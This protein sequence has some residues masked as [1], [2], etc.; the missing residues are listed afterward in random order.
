[1]DPDLKRPTS[2]ELSFNIEREITSGLSG[3]ASYVYKNMR[4]VWGEYDA[5]RG[6]Q[7]TVPITIVDPGPDNRLSTPGDNQ[8]FETFDRPAGIDQD[9]VYTNIPDAD[10]SFQTIEFAVNRRFADRWMLLTSFGYTWSSMLHDVTGYGRLTNNQTYLPVK[11]LFGDNGIETSTTWNYKV[12]GRYV[13]PWDIGL[14]GSWKAQS[15]QNFGRTH[16]FRFPGDGNRTFRVEP[17][18]TRRYPNVN[19]L[20]FRLDKSFGFSRY[21]KLTA[22]FD[23]FNL[24]NSGVPTSF[25]TTSA[26]FL[27]VTGILAP[28]VM[29]FG[30]RYDF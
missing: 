1:V 26:N 19:I 16:T 29:R 22:Q 13:L 4:N 2:N 30:L 20:D 9:R 23:V 7:Y 12:I 17:I 3:R 6:P 8:T 11:R 14:S 27:E 21:G 15:G 5:I 24:T 10:A 18:G 25:R 28:R